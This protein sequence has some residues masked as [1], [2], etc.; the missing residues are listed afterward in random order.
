M[1]LLD[2]RILIERKSINL[3]FLGKLLKRDLGFP[4]HSSQT[5]VNSKCM[6]RVELYF[7]MC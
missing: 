6:R 3:N 1:P 5:L 2:L 7:L 4:N